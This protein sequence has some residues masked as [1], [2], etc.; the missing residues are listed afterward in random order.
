MLWVWY[1]PQSLPL[2]LIISV[3]AEVEAA[4]STG[5]PFTLADIL[6]AAGIE[7]ALVH[8]VS[9]HGSAWQTS[10]TFGPLLHHGL[11][12]AGVGAKPEIAIQAT[13]QSGLPGGFG[14]SMPAVELQAGIEVLEQ[15]ALAEVDAESKK[16]M[17][18][19]IE[20]SW[21][22]SIQME[23][24]CTALRQKL[25]SMMAALG[26]LDRDLAPDERLAADREDRDAWQEARRWM[27]DLMAKCHR[28]IKSFDIGM[29]SAAGKR[30]VIE[31]LYQQII[32]PRAACSELPDMRREFEAYRKDMTN[33]QKTMQSTL[34]TSG[35]NG[36]QRAHRVLAV[37][38]KKIRARR[39]RMREALGGT[40]IDKSVRRKS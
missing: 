37:I 24:Q 7:T 21:R 27:R 31:Q 22:S 11:P 16:M 29:T 39:A 35:Q 32:E 20:Q 18:E 13:Q 30:N 3:P 25:A 1:R 17:Y 12:P 28:E 36:S 8:S 5:F 33:L 2:G 34:Q 15:S 6:L 19:R 38:S 10:A 23:R 40:N 9:I 14:V 4:Y 26:K